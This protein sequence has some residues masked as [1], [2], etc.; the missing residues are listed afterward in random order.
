MNVWV[1]NLDAEDE[2]AL[3]G[4]AHTPSQAM[5]ERIR[6]LL[7]ALSSLVGNDR[8]V[9]PLPRGGGQGEGRVHCWSPTR[10]AIKTV[11]DAGLPMPPA[12]SMTTLIRV[13]SRRFSAELG[14]TLP[15]ARYGLD[16]PSS[17]EWLLKRPFGYAGK[18]RRKINAASLT[19]TDRAFI[20]ASSELQIEPWVTREA[21][22]ALHGWLCE[23]GTYEL[24]APTEQLVDDTGAW[25]STRITT[26]LSVSE[27]DALT[28]EATRAAHALHAAG[29]FGPF[30]LDAFRWRD[31]H[32]THF[33]P[34][35]E[36]NARFS[37][38][39]ATGMGAAGRRV[40]NSGG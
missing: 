17:G 30:N 31:A 13:N 10:F 27:L 39:W 3:G 29:Y 32:G 11:L 37:M 34:R 28:H 4:R 7:P 22:F 24:G 19:A 16:V 18:G 14:Q 6:G 25:Q 40:L 1:L 38:G 8:I 36:I 9:F 23:D 26:G 15:G 5:V 12:P 21:D 20:A 33:Q 35:S 2:L